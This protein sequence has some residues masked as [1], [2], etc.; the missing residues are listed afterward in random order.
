MQ[1]K[2]LL[3]AVI[4]ML[5]IGV[6]LYVR[7]P[8]SKNLIP[9]SNPTPKAESA[10]TASTRKQDLS[11]AEKGD[12]RDVPAPWVAVQRPFSAMNREE[13]RAIADRIRKL[14]T[15]AIFHIWISARRSEHDFDKQYIVGVILQD[16]IREKPADSETVQQFQ[17]F[18]NDDSNSLVERARLLQVF[19]GAATKETLDLLLQSATNS[20]DSKLKKIA[21]NEVIAVGKLRGDGSFHEELSPALERAWSSSGD[22]DL[23]NSAAIA[24]AKVGAPSGVKLLIDSAIS[25]ASPTDFRA[26]MAETALTTTMNPHAIPVV[27]EVLL[28][29]TTADARSKIASRT[30]AEIGRADAIKV[31]IGWFQN[32]DDGAAVLVRNCIKKIRNNA[33]L[34]QWDSA[35]GPSAQFHSEIN[36]EAIKAALADF[37]KRSKGSP[38]ID[39]TGR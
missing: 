33:E 5:A 8:A 4:A 32:A 9:A 29:E 25:T 6:A 27:S 24:M 7:G 15:G 10:V 12:G 36:R 14:D 37:Q 34:Q 17:S 23:L 31:L 22:Q 35:V 19:G 21:N 28:T 39:T 11:I 26:R 16:A 20:K 1:R 38:A 30:L 18:V 13:R 3:G 2:L